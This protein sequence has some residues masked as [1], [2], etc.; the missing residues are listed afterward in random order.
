MEGGTREQDIRL[1]R[2]NDWREEMTRRGDLLKDVMTTI[3]SN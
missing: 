2:G 1:K 3:L